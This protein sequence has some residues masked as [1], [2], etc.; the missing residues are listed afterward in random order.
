MSVLSL[1]ELVAEQLDMSVFNHAYNMFNV[2]ILC[3]I[4]RLDGYRLWIKLKVHTMVELVGEYP[5]VLKLLTYMH[6]SVKE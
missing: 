6:L 4:N 2:H 3:D 1:N 5:R